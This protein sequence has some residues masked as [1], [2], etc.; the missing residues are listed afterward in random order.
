MIHFTIG[1]IPVPKGRPRLG[2]GCVYTPPATVEYEDK[3]RALAYNYRPPTPLLEEI[4]VT[5][6]FSFI[7]GPHSKARWPKPDTDNL[8]KAASDAF[9]GLFWKDDSQ[10]GKVTGMKRFSPIGASVAVWIQPYKGIS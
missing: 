9:N 5:F 3:L 6:I 1:I 2:R 8:I 7:K 4:E 10:I